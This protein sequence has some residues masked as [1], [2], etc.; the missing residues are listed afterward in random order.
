MSLLDFGNTNYKQANYASEESTRLANALQAS[1]SSIRT[2]EIAA[3]A[4][5]QG[6]MLGA[7]V[8]AV[9][10]YKS[11]PKTNANT[12]TAISAD[13]VNPQGLGAISADPVNPQGL[14]A[15]SADPVNP[16]GLGKSSSVGSRSSSGNDLLSKFSNL[17]E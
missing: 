13:P 4:A 1:R 15:I 7:G 14:G 11:A 10:D 5:A 8:G 3:K 12:S 9:S 16:Q 6:A 17:F 2:Q